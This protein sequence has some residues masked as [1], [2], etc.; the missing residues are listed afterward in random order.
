VAHADALAL[1]GQLRQGP[2]VDEDV[3]HVEDLGHVG[4]RLW[5]G[6]AKTI[7]TRRVCAVAE[8]T[9]PPMSH[10]PDPRARLTPAM[11]GVIDRIARAGHP[12][13][14]A[15]TPEQARQAYAAGA[16]VL[17]VSPPAMARTQDLRIRTRDGAEL[18]ARLY[19][20]IEADGL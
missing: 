17:E 19:L 1:G 4:L 14:H 18:P 3:C 5:F 9:S 8:P 11:R 2:V 10:H 12:P 15:L 13:F 20:P 7:R 6:A 16:G